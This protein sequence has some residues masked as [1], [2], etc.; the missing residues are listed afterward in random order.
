[1]ARVAWAMNAV[2][3]Q[4]S[5]ADVLAQIVALRDQA[6]TTSAEE[7]VF[8]FRHQIA[9]NKSSAAAHGSLRPASAWFYLGL[10]VVGGIVACASSDA[11]ILWMCNNVYC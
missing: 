6:R 11:C 5:P 2:G 9:E 10:V 8:A 4:V 1:M 7:F 3:D